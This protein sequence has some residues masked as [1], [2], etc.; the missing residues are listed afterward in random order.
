MLSYVLLLLLFSQPS[1]KLDEDKGKMQSIS[2]SWAAVNFG[3]D[4]AATPK[5]NLDCKVNQIRLRMWTS[6]E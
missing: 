5:A 2:D 4:T 1:Y 3:P 6:R